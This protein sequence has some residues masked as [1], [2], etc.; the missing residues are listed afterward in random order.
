[1]QEPTS[2][3]KIIQ[4]TIK[5]KLKAPVIKLTIKHTGGYHKS[6]KEGTSW[7]QG[8]KSL[9]LPL[10]AL[11]SNYFQLEIKTTSLMFISNA[12]VTR[13]DI[14]TRYIKKINQ[15]VNLFYFGNKTK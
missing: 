13:K 7:R 12:H 15:R 2:N 6:K 5:S 14:S 9:P 10:L 4:P 11:Q 1:M 3:R 8:Q